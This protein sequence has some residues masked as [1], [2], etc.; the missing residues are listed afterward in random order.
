MPEEITLNQI[1]LIN[2]HLKELS[3]EK[4]EINPKIKKIYSN[5]K[6]TKRKIIVS[7]E[8]FNFNSYENFI[9]YKI[10]DFDENANFSPN[11]YIAE[12]EFEYRV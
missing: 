9:K 4:I 11:F 6:A 12:K 5:L 10:R 1:N 7:N 3:I 2:E 8:N